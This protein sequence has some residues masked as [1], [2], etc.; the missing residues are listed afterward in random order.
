MSKKSA[1]LYLDE[2]LVKEAKFLGF[3]ISRT[4]ELAL[5]RRIK[6]EKERSPYCYH[7]NSK[8]CNSLLNCRD[9]AG[10]AEPGQRR[11]TQDP[12]P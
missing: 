4:V 3:N 2:D 12:F 6:A 9:A 5:E 7:E 1:T 10:V 8:E 11:G